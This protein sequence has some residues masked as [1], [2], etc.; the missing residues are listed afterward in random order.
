MS[1]VVLVIS[2]MDITYLAFFDY[3]NGCEVCQTFTLFRAN[4]EYRNQSAKAN[5]CN[6]IKRE[7]SWQEYLT[8]K[9]PEGGENTLEE[10]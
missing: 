3:I 9:D 10:K 6:V 5:L 4:I 1:K 2:P 8:F 7:L